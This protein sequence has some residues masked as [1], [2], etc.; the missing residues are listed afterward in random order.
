MPAYDGGDTPL[1]I[2]WED[3]GYL[4][5]PNDSTPKSLGK[6]AQLETLE[7]TRNGT[8]VYLP[9]S[10][11][12]VDIKSGSRIEGSWGFRAAVSTPWI[13]RAI[14]GAPS[15]S[16]NGDGTYTHTFDGT[17][18]PFRILIGI[19]GIGDERTIAGCVPVRATVE[20]ST[21]EDLGGIV[22]ME[23]FYADEPDLA[24]PASLTSQPDS[25][26]GVLD[27]SDATFDLDGSTQTIMQQST[28]T[29][30]YPDLGG[31][32]GFGSRLPV[33]YGVRAFEPSLDYSKLKVDNAPVTDIYDGS[34]SLQEDV[35]SLKPVTQTFD[36]EQTGSSMER[37][38]FEGSGSFPNS[39]GESGHG[40][41]RSLL[42]EELNRMLSDVTIKAR[43][44]TQ[45][46]P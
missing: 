15:T 19:E 10:R 42:E 1:H 44:G 35:A 16:S 13:Y 22:T 3:N 7:L 20:T 5:A 17:P 2:L 6:A 46:P 38:I 32:V 8:R 11:T 12:P 45:T 14:K 30:E 18:D 4:N 21:D 40:N 37:L 24:T 9:A 29:L 43:N 28:W 41:P 33:D 36:N 34:G 25:G 27:A 26:F 39:L 23:G 31:V